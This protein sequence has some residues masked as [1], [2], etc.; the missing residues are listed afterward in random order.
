LPEVLAGLGHVAEGVY[1]AA[2]VVR[3][4]QAMG[5]EMPIAEAVVDVLASRLH[6]AEA[7]TRLMARQARPE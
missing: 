3:R 7:V 2:T 4:A 5:V 6:P 1:S